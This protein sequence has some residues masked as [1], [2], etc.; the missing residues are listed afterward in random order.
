TGVAVFLVAVA[1]VM[2]YE[3]ERDVRLVP[4]EGV[5]VS[6][7]QFRFQG[8]SRVQGPNYSAERGEVEVSRNGR[9]FT[10][11]HPEKRHHPGQEMPMTKAALDRGLFRDLYVSLGDPLG[12]GAWVVRVYYKPYMSWMWSG[13]LLM[14]FGGVLAAADRRY[15]LAGARSAAPA[16]G[17]A[18]AYPAGGS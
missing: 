14:V 13:C 16:P 8:I 4:G 18:A 3:V 17:S 15:R 1:M 9:L 5:E 10:T 2:T 12:G 6:G 7:Y 11:L